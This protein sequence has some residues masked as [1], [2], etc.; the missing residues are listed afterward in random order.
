[1]AAGEYIGNFLNKS[2][3]DQA[4]A[5]HYPSSGTPT[6]A[7][8][9]HVSY[10]S[11]A[12]ADLYT[13]TAYTAAV[14]TVRTW[15]PVFISTGGGGGGMGLDA[16]AVNSLIAMHNAAADAHA[17]IRAL[18]PAHNIAGD[19]HE[20]I[21]TQV[22]ANNVPYQ[23]APPT[24]PSTGQRYIDSDDNSLY[25]WDGDSWE[26]LGGG[27]GTTDYDA[28]N[29]RPV[30]RVAKGSSRPAAV[31]DNADQVMW[32]E[33]VKRFY[34]NVLQPGHDASATWRDLTTAD[35]RSLT[36]DNDLNFRGTRGDYSALPGSPAHNDVYYLRNEDIFVWYS[37]NIW[38]TFPLPN[39]VHGHFVTKTAADHA[40]ASLVGSGTGTGYVAAF[41]TQNIL[42]E[43]A[44]PRYSTAYTA[45][46][47][48]S[49]HWADWQS[50]IVTSLGRKLE[51]VGTPGDGQVAKWSSANSRWQP[52][53]DE[54]GSPGSGEE[55]VQSDWDV[56]DNA[57]DAFILNKPDIDED[58]DDS[59]LSRS[60]MDTRFINTA[61]EVVTGQ[62][63]AGDGGK[64]PTVAAG[65]L[66]YHRKGGD[67]VP[68]ADGGTGASTVAA[69]RTNLGLG[70]AATR[71]VGVA[72][73]NL[74]ELQGSQNFHPRRLAN[75]TPD[76]LTTTRQFLRNNTATT[77]RWANFDDA[78]EG[79]IASE[80]HFSVEYAG[81]YDEDVTY[82]VGQHVDYENNQ[83]FCAN[84]TL[85]NANAPS[86][87][88]PASTTGWQLWSGRSTWRGTF[89]DDD[90]TE[91]AFVTGD[92][93]RISG[94]HNYTLIGVSGDYT[95]A[96]IYNNGNGAGLGWRI[97]LERADI[98]SGIIERAISNGGGGFPSDTAHSFIVHEPDPENRLE[99]HSA[100][101]T[102]A[103]LLDEGVHGSPSDD[104]SLA[105]DN[106]NS[107]YHW[108]SASGLSQADA[109]ARYL[110]KD[111]T[112][113]TTTQTIEDPIVVDVQGN[114]EAFKIQAHDVTSSAIFKIET[115][116]GGSQKAF[117]AN[118]EGQSLAFMEF[119]GAVGG[120]GKPGIAMGAGTG[121]RD[122]NL[123]REDN[124]TLRT[125]DTFR[126]AALE[127]SSTSGYVTTRAN[128]SLGNAFIDA[129]EQSGGG[130]HFD[131]PDGGDKQLSK[132][133][134]QTAVGAG[135]GSGDIPVLDANGRLAPAR[136]GSG[137]PNNE[138]LLR[139]DRVWSTLEELVDNLEDAEKTSLLTAL[140]AGGDTLSAAMERDVGW[141]G[142]STNAA[143]LT[144]LTPPTDCK[145]IYIAFRHDNDDAWE[146]GLYIDYV[147]WNAFTAVASG[148]TLNDS[149][150]WT[151]RNVT[152]QLAS[153]WRIGKGTSGVLAVG[154]SRTGSGERFDKICVR[155]VT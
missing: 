23:A 107:R 39:H 15:K 94:D 147:I 69:A 33:N 41:D 70:S 105:W 114:Q 65:D 29:N 101:D 144:T 67:D 49:R 115:P 132:S 9:K 153:E 140:G 37:T 109:D 48:D 18:I 111:T 84:A 154:S 11:F 80:V 50:G 57:S 112:G 92:R 125:D 64:L 17:D 150:A 59:L 56:T 118:R 13:I 40:L 2:L 82:E 10:G 77:A 22:L 89:E 124:H 58:N 44:Q 21:R 61:T 93:L 12:Q 142:V 146:G 136:M 3:A 35:V 139:G 91:Y 113:T 60:A 129:T 16:A 96:Y 127:I 78:V 81:E 75:N 36:G 141:A 26:E 117:Q 71:D 143:I 63:M 98:T 79:I 5:A 85:A 155:W 133:D 76:A 90:T 25:F 148:G 120:T 55:N 138:K 19:A 28:L 86:T 130:L 83:Y 8:G 149:N 47:A 20:D 119:G 116:T 68:I 73:D 27:G 99:F 1:M 108:I 43:Q 30:L 145:M 151:Y 103:A 66:R 38:Q 100:T 74:V 152:P 31:D 123:Y 97:Q 62:V 135:T 42:R 134:M 87:T 45:A 122:V 53:D 128:L 6:D 14:P 32:D 88:D 121:G 51:V 102:L 137:N 34:V 4:V 110:Q 46:V 7:V 104:Q 24:N 106:T 52:A 131:R 72:N 54:V 126:A 95:P